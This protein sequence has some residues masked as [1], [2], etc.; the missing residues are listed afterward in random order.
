MHK[1]YDL[2]LL[3]ELIKFNH[4]G[5]F[6][7]AMSLMVGMYHTRELYNA[8]VKEILE[9]RSTDDWFSNNYH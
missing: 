2:A 5:N 4:M 1:I 8:E 3:Q 7:R 9:D 6:D